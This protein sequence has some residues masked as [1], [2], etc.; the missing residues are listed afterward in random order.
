MEEVWQPALPGTAL[1]LEAG[2]PT[3]HLAIENFGAGAIA[4]PGLAALTWEGWLRTREP[5]AAGT[6]ADYAAEGGG[7]QI[8]NPANL[9]ITLNGEA[10]PAQ[11]INLADGRWHHLAFSWQSATGQL[12]LYVD[13]LNRYS[14][15]LAQGGT[16]PLGGTLRLGARQTGSIPF[17][18]YLSEVST[19][20][21]VLSADE[22]QAHRHL[23][24]T[25]DEPGLLGYWSMNDVGRDVGRDRSPHGHHATPVGS[26]SLVPDTAPIGQLERDSASTLVVANEYP[27]QETNEA[28]QAV[29][30]M[31]RFYAYIQSGAFIEALQDRRIETLELR[32]VGNAQ[33]EPT[34]LGYIEGAPPVPSENLTA[35]EDYNGTAAI[36]LTSTENV[37]Y[38]W[39][40]AQEAGLGVEVDAILGTAAEVSAGF[41]V[42]TSVEG[43]FGFTGNL[44]SSYSL[45]DEGTVTLDITNAFQDR[46]SLRGS[47]EDTER[48][49]HLGKRFIPK[50]VGYAL[51]VSSL[52]DVFV[53]RLHRSRRMV[54]YQVAPVPDLPPQ[55]NTITF[56]INPAYQQNGTLDGQVGTEAAD[57]R[58]YAE[59]PSLRAQYGSQFPA[60]YFRLREAA[61]LEAK[62]RRQD[63][64]R[65]AI[66]INYNSR[67]I[68]V[69][70]AN[71]STDNANEDNIE[72]VA[73]VAGSAI[74]S[75]L[76]TVG[77][78][79]SAAGWQRRLEQLLVEARKRNMI[80]TY[81]WDGDGGLRS[82]T[83]EFA[84]TIEQTI[85]G[86][87][88]LDGG[89][90]IT[91]FVQGGGVWVELTAL[92]TAH[93]TQVSTKTESRSRGFSLDIE[94][95]GESRGITRADDTAVIPGEK[96][97]SLPLLQ[98]LPGAGY[99]PL[100][101]LLPPGSRSRVADEQRRRGPRPAADQHGAAQPG[102]A[103][104]APGNVCGASGPARVW[105]SSGGPGGKPPGNGGPVY[106]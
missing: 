100:R 17:L 105:G 89:L 81:V 65:E 21:E 63:R 27:T 80:N 69:G 39:T 104:A 82:A 55:V 84:D 24:L 83:Q 43:G 74:S 45:L 52:A 23:F 61:E 18:G 26:V 97:R 9:Q 73:E 6:V 44:S 70:S 57:D 49:P 88:S 5:N 71:R 56:L 58:F 85:G 1:A 4:A 14:G 54:S 2:T 38:S 94:L 59:V 15:R 10:T 99:Q 91:G 101:R 7:W 20:S 32:W 28:G 51:V 8:L 36:Q 37:S 103:G 46:L 34:L 106:N 98:L 66:F 41:I 77:S 53:L 30:L 86:S 93:L 87:F 29:A 40:R 79:G 92:A 19:W 13:G 96:G 16:I 42:M 22:I 35:A 64:E 33:F 60:S 3:A 75:T 31:R 72:Q 76:E 50:N 62:I 78:G 90:G 95:E 102:V 11:A 68:A 67:A 47:Q 48:F 12:H 25:G